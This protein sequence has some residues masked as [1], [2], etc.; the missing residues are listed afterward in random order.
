MRLKPLKWCMTGQ[1]AS[2]CAGISFDLEAGLCHDS[3]LYRWDVN[4][5]EIG[6]IASGLS[7]T[8]QQAIDEAG[9]AY[10]KLLLDQLEPDNE[11][12]S[13]PDTQDR[14][15]DIAGDGC[16]IT[17]TSKSCRGCSECGRYRTCECDCGGG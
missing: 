10:L 13:Q 15:Q 2:A 17:H 6:S 7:A 14:G 3:K 16:G 9:D 1:S 4:V 11:P 8:L 12:A 5:D